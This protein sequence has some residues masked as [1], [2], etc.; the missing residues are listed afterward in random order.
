[1]DFLKL[2]S[3]NFTRDVLLSE[4]LVIVLFTAEWCGVTHI[5]IPILQFL[6]S[7]YSRKIRIYQVDINSSPEITEQ[8]GVHE[9]PTILFLYKGK[10]MDHLTGIF[11]QIDMEHK[12]DN[13]LQKRL[14]KG[15][16]K[17]N[18]ND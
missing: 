1:V 17:S 7:N 16:Y 10:I 4:K 6:Y 12:L 15:M 3:E 18:T 11:S 2:T 13:I 9:I 5:L 14:K 8:Y